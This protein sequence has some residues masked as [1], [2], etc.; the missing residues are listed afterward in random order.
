MCL[1]A[2][3]RQAKSCIL[4]INMS[5]QLLPK[6]NTADTT[7]IPVLT[8]VHYLT[9]VTTDSVHLETLLSSSATVTNM[10]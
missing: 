8:V 6:I 9:S 5:T 2:L 10:S 1:I 3:R 4:T 7:D